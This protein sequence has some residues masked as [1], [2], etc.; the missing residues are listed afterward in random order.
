MTAHQKSRSFLKIII[1]HWSSFLE[2]S[3]KNDIAID[4]WGPGLVQGVRGAAVDWVG[5]GV[6]LHRLRHVGQTKR[7]GAKFS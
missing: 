1:F 6:G 3:Q 2:L 4:T 7:T 5:A